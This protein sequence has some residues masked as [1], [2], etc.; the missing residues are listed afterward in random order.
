MRNT[1]QVSIIIPVFNYAHFL[2]RTLDSIFDQ[3][4]RDYEVIVVDDGS[5]DDPFAIIKP[6]GNRVQYLRQENK[7]VCA[8]RNAG[9]QIAKGEYVLFLDADDFIVPDKLYA[10]VALMKASPTYGIVHSGWWLADSDGTVYDCVTPWDYAPLLD[11]ETWLFWKPV[12]PASMLLRKSIID[13]VGGFDPAFTQAEDVD[14]IF[15][16]MMTGCEAI[17]LKRPTAYYR[18]HPDNTVKNIKGQV[19]NMVRVLEKYFS[20][21]NL[22]TQIKNLESRIWHSS[23]MWNCADLFEGG[24]INEVKTYLALATEKSRKTYHDIL[25]DFFRQLNKNNRQLIENGYLKEFQSELL[26]TVLDKTPSLDQNLS[27]WIL[28]DAFN[29]L[30]RIYDLASQSKTYDPDYY[31]IHQLSTRQIVKILSLQIVGNYWLISSKELDKLWSNFRKAGLVPDADRY[32]VI[33]LFLTLFS[34]C[35]FSLH[36]PQAV[37]YLLST[38]SRSMNPRAFSPWYRFFLSA[39]KFIFERI[40]GKS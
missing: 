31:K 13:A 29:E 27:P 2:K 22:S 12:L 18:Q 6:Y 10:Q 4:Y 23:L 39:I 5:E 3:T 32:E 26:A 35:V 14:L 9:L 8:A 17:W 30:V 7:G 24:H 20:Q 19:E 40:S 28:L 25:I 1:P 15:R 16:M 11:I 36:W 37:G 34:Q 21:E 33:T 38:V